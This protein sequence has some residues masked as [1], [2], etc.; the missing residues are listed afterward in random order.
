MK[1]LIILFSFSL[2]L[3]IFSGCSKDKLNE[4][5]R[6]DKIIDYIE[7]DNTNTENTN[8]IEGSQH[9]EENIDLSNIKEENQ[10]KSSKSDNFIYVNWK[11]LDD[12]DL[13]LDL[14]AVLVGNNKLSIKDRII[15]YTNLELSNQSVIHMGDEKQESECIY[16]NLENIPKDVEKIY[17][18][19]Y[20][21]T[22]EWRN[23]KELNVNI[24]TLNKSVTTDILPMLLNEDIYE[25]ENMYNQLYGTN[26]EET[27]EIEEIEE[28]TNLEVED[29]NDIEKNKKSY[30]AIILCS[31]ERRQLDWKLSETVEFIDDFNQFL[32]NKGINSDIYIEVSQSEKTPVIDSNEISNNNNEEG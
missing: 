3:L 30:S 2:I 20:N 24:E 28:T 14:V 4:T 31:Y 10:N 29:L 11:S 15:N 32:I 21:C 18:I 26:L 7:V 1:K 25:L 19:C 8:P 6:V 5:L 13:D 27:E 12:S 17:L 22:K 9:N 23:L 16:L